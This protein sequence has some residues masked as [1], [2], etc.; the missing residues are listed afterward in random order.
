[1]IFVKKNDKRLFNGI[2]LKLE[3]VKA[4]FFLMRDNATIDEET[5]DFIYNTKFY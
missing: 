2:L 1:M 5:C 3:M 4:I